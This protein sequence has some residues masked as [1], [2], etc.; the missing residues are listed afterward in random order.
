MTIWAFTAALVLSGAL[1]VCEALRQRTSAS[2]RHYILAT[3]FAVVLAVPFVVEAV[4]RIEP[5]RRVTSFVVLTVTPRAAGEKPAPPQNSEPFRWTPVLGGVW[6]LGASVCLLRLVLARRTQWQRS[7]LAAEGETIARSL[8]IRR[9]VRFAESDAVAVPET[10]GLFRPVVVLPRAARLWS[11]ERLHVVLTHELIHVARH[12]WVVSVIAEAAAALHWFNPLAWI[13]LRRLRA[14]R[15][16]ACDDA[17]LAHGVGPCDY[18]EHLIGI[19]AGLRSPES[20][21]SVA[22]AQTTQLEH[23]IRSILNP[24]LRRGGVSMKSKWS[25]SAVA[26]L[27]LTT[28]VGIQAP[29]QSGTAAL[30][31]TVYDPS[32]ARVPQAS[33]IV[34]NAASKGV[35]ITRTNETGEFSFANLPTGTYTLEVARAGFQLYKQENIVLNAGSAQNVSAIL[36]VGRINET[37]NVNAQRTAPKPAAADTNRPPQRLRI[38]GNMQAAKIVKMVRPEYPANM[39]A[40]GV[41]GTVL[42]EAVIG[43]DGHLMN[44][45][46]TNT[47]VHADLIAAATQAVQGWQWEPTYL[48][49]E[50]VEVVTMI[51]INFTLA[52]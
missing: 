18:A 32:S 5:I 27:A 19:V 14:E 28:L 15:E 26:A 42:L 52:P 41:E 24:H 17:V 2:V 39:K 4:R 8:G 37:V 20:A 50:P 47:Q 11:D 31:G 30:S 16:A 43:R 3:A 7:A 6:A 44:L 38:G 40:A 13:A 33:V 29:A 45:Q 21:T 9:N 34:R 25:V 10:R 23:R 36:N 48:N 22:M 12:D 1:A 51:T 49:G 46:V 35:E